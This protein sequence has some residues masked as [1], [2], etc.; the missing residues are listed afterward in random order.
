MHYSNTNESKRVKIDKIASEDF[1]AYNSHA[2]NQENWSRMRS[3]DQCTQNTIPI[4]R[5]LRRGMYSIYFHFFRI[6]SGTGN[7]AHAVPFI[8]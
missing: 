8:K 4:T 3:T 2:N 6:H 7:T 5:R 1:D